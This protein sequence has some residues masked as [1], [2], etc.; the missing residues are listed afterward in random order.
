MGVFTN[1]LRSV[2]NGV[3]HLEPHF[4]KSAGEKYLDFLVTKVKPIEEL[5][6]ILRELVHVPT[7]ALVMHLANDDPENLFS[8]SFRTLPSSSNGVPHIL[9]HTVLCGSRRFPVKDP[10]FAMHRRSLN[11]FMNAFTGSDFTC[12]PAASQVEKDFYNLLDVYIDA[13]FHPS[14]KRESF[15]QEGHRFE[16]AAPDNPKSPLEIKGIVFNEM[17]GSLAS[18]DARLWHQMLAMLT[19]DLPYAYNSGGDPHDIPNLTYAELIS[20]HETYYQ[21]SRCLFFFYGNFPLKKHLDFI[22]EKILKQ[23]QKVAPIPPI[24][25]QKRF[26][27]PVYHEMRYPTSEGEGQKDRSIVGLGWLTCPLVHQED[28]LA[29]CVLDSVLMENDGSPLKKRLLASKLCVSVDAF[30]DTEMSEVPYAMVFKGCAPTSAEAIE[31][32]LRRALN[33]IIQE[34]V[35]THLIEAAILQLELA[36]LEIAGEHTPFGLT[37]FMR[38]ALA[39]QHGSEPETAL[40]VYSLFEGLLGKIRDPQYLPGLIQKYLLDNTHLVRLVMQPDPQLTEAEARAEKEKLLK[41]Q[42][43]LKAAEIEHILKQTEELK[44]YQ[45]HTETQS[46][47]CLPKVTLQDVSPLIRDFALKRS[48]HGNLE[49]FHHDCF[50][51]HVLYADLVFDIPHIEDRDLPLAHLLTSLITEVGCANRNYAENL[52]YTHAHTGGIGAA[53]AL[54]PQVDDPK[55]A[56]PCFILRGKALARKA[57][58]LFE[59]LHDTLLHPRFDERAR[60]SDLL[61]Q[62][63]EGL[64]QKLNRQ[65]MRYAVQLAMSGLSHSGY[66]GEAWHGLRYYRE[67]EALTSDL[68]RHLPDVIERLVNMRETLITFHQPHLVLS[69]SKEMYDDLAKHD[70]YGIGNFPT[71][72]FTPWKFDYPLT[73][74]PS[75]ART[76]AS[77]VAFNVYAFRTISY[78][79]PHSAALTVIAILFDHLVLHKRI[80]EQGGAY[81][82]GCSFV[83]SSGL[84]YFHSYRDPHIASTLHTFKEAIDLLAESHFTDQNLEEAKLVIIQQFDSPISPGSR[85]IS[86][87]GW[88][89]DGKTRELRQQFRDRLLALTRQE[90]IHILKM[91]ILPKRDQGVAVC[92]AGRELIEKDNQVLAERGQPLQV[93]PI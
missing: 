70:F 41:I 93:L 28:V 86:A 65:A 49:V 35:P 3:M 74:L 53:C 26:T 5:N 71:K 15:L 9:E 37:L 8:L 83:S 20:F 91:E 42:Q 44:I 22:S 80:R 6:C 25:R 90:I 33:E 13:V 38:S 51:N 36:R 50:T 48:K 7:G 62:I 69:C 43:S 45:K 84:F 29:L 78:I 85:A 72:P 81:G 23:A 75:Q 24:A 54:H 67:I 21:P 18:A 79:H 60:I 89:R 4:L 32:L 63:R 58:K 56:R 11:T 68:K 77:Q 17:K 47:D 82:S 31:T 30:L 87:Y 66:I 88:W 46:L 1:R 64:Q 34:G 55:L 19:P 27:K 61:K 16:F 52:E 40:V 12:Y 39:K 2:Y 57:D 14:L 92:I 10:F 59:V 76:L 73:P